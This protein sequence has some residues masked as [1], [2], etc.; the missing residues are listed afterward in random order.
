MATGLSDLILGLREAEDRYRRN[1]ADAFAG[2]E[3]RI[4]GMIDVAPFTPKMFIDLDGAENAF[5]GRPGTEIAEADV[6]VFL[7][8]VSPYYTINDDAIRRLHIAN[9][10]IIPYDTAVTEVNEY[11]KRAWSGMPVWPGSGS[12][13]TNLAQWPSRLVHLFGSEYGW[14]ED[15]T[16]NLPFRRLWQYANRILEEVN[17][18]FKERCPEAMRLRSEWLMRVNAEEQ[19]EAAAKKGRN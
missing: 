7:W 10:A 15:Y 5:F 1:N 17:A 9:S 16:L 11:I 13:E 8:R 6:A 19:A 3:P 12:R 4:C 18:D 14:L 2:I